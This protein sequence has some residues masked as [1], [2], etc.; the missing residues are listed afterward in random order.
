[1]FRDTSTHIPE[2]GHYPLSWVHGSRTPVEPEE[3]IGIDATACIV[4]TASSDHSARIWDPRSGETI[5]TLQ[6]HES[7]VLSA[8]FWGSQ[9]WRRTALG[10]ARTVSGKSRLWLADESSQD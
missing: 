7:G 10:F 9:R 4:T 5:A 6:G 1:M 8:A 3:W 2:I